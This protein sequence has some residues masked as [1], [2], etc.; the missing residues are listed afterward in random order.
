MSTYRVRTTKTEN[1]AM[2]FQHFRD[3]CLQVLSD[4]E[5]LTDSTFAP[6]I[7]AAAGRLQSERVKLLVVGEFSRG[8]S[9]FINALLGEPLLPSRVTPTTAGIV[10]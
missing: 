1:L 7:A 9:T 6:R 4:L 2:E 10:T 5:A 3:T 8:K